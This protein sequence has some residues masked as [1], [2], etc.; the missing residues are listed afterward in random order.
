MR[1]D[2]GPVVF[3]KDPGSVAC[4]GF[5]PPTVVPEAVKVRRLRM[6]GPSQFPPFLGGEFC[7]GRVRQ[8]P[9]C[10]GFRK[11]D[12]G[13][14][15]AAGN[16]GVHRIFEAIFWALRGRHI[17]SG[18]R[19]GLTGHTC[20][21]TG[22]RAGARGHA[23]SAHAHGFIAASA[24]RLPFSRQLLRTYVRSYCGEVGK[25]SA[26]DSTPPRFEP[27]LINWGEEGAAE[28]ILA[29]APCLRLPSSASCD[30]RALRRPLL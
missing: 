6:G 28:I 23:P 29:R 21:G 11:P 13:I 16:R 2:A 1:G 14:P 17:A 9:L 15:A 27:W 3:E 24:S 25:A 26:N 19:R 4:L 10:A 12:R 20:D 18:S 5:I 30:R 22:R 7:D 8:H